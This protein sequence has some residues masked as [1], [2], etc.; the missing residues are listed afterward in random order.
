VVSV[1]AVAEFLL[2][3]ALLLVFILIEFLLRVVDSPGT[4]V[5]SGTNEAGLGQRQVGSLCCQVANLLL[6]C[7]FIA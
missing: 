5:P 1:M 7:L 6:G 3:D 2:L 4:P